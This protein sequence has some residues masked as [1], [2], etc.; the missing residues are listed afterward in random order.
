MSQEND[1]YH[2]REQDFAEKEV[3]MYDC[4]LEGAGGGE[5]N[6][7]IQMRTYRVFIMH[8]GNNFLP[9]EFMT[10]ICSLL[11]IGNSSQAED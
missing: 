3:T 1:P 6:K 4:L 9:Y 2:E 10:V 7:S 5:A 11:M 8:C